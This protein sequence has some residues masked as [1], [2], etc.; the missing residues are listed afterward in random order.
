MDP[1]AP[2]GPNNGHALTKGKALSNAMRTG[3]RWLAGVAAGALGA[4]L[5]VGLTAAPAQANTYGVSLAFPSLTLV[6]TN[7]TAP[8]IP[9]TFTVNGNKS[10]LTGFNLVGQIV[11]KDD[12]SV[13]GTSTSTFFNDV[14]RLNSQ[15]STGVSSWTLTNGT[16]NSAA[17]Y[18]SI[19]TG[20]YTLKV[21]ATDATTG[22]AVATTSMPFAVVSAAS[23]S[24][25]AGTAAF[26]SAQDWATQKAA[27]PLTVSTS[28]SVSAAGTLNVAFLNS[29]GGPIV[30]PVGMFTA[31]ASPTSVSGGSSYA[32]VAASGT[33]PGIYAFSG[34]S[35]TWSST[36]TTSGTVKAYF[37][38]PI[39]QITGTLGVTVSSAATMG[40]FNITSAIIGSAGTMTTAADDSA[41]VPTTSGVKFTVSAVTNTT[42]VSTSVPT[43]GVPVTFSVAGYQG[44]NTTAATAYSA[45][46]PALPVAT[47]SGGGGV[48]SQEFTVSNPVASN[49][50][51]V[52]ATVPGATYTWFIQFSTPTV[53]SVSVATRNVTA[54]N[55]GTVTIAGTVLDNFDEPVANWPVQAA[56]TGVAATSTPA[57]LTS[58][59]D[60]NV[61][62][63]ITV[64]AS[65]PS[66]AISN[67][68][69]T[70]WNSSA[71]SFTGT[72]STVVVTYTSGSA[73]VAT[74]TTQGSFSPL[75]SAA[76]ANLGT[77][78]K[79]NTA[80]N[81]MYVN[82]AANLTLA[83][84]PSA[85]DGFGWQI[86]TTATNAAGTAIAGAAIEVAAGDGGYVVS[87]ITGKWVKEATF[88]TSST[89]VNQIVFGSTKTGEITYTLK[90]GSVTQTVA[91]VYANRPT[92]ART[93]A[94]ASSSEKVPAG[95]GATITATV[96]DRFGN[97]V[98]GVPVTFTETGPGYI[99]G[100]GGGTSGANGRLEATY[101]TVG[102]QSGTATVGAVVG[103]TA[104]VSLPSALPSAAD[105][106]PAAA[107]TYTLQVGNAADTVTSYA[108]PAAS[109]T[110]VSSTVRGVTAGVASA[111]LVIEVTDVASKSITIVGE[112]TTVS[113][114]SG[115]KVDGIV[116]GIE[117]GK[118]V[119]PFIRFP[120]E[121]TFTEG[122]ARPAIS[123][124]EFTW[125]RKTGKR[126]TVYVTSDD[127]LVTSNRVTIQA[128]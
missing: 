79:L 113:G 96:T 14:T 112:R 26:V 86:K 22:V 110:A 77:G 21:T 43:A 51:R 57:S 24:G 55:T 15:A 66:G 118:T 23:A 52:T 99:A 40:S 84:A 11:D 120:G 54:A 19:A 80:K 63:T 119:K 76:F 27:T 90:S 56:V 98:P 36:P 2:G 70:P 109:T 12:S 59:K 58:D 81:P 92:D 103:S 121:T 13:I 53:S 9:V 33:A 74:L 45:I 97:P 68:T 28:S 34:A 122:T 39:N 5:L 78:N 44:N 128:S 10:A 4:G 73:A 32:T 16:S 71:G 25:V 69:F 29:A 116:E 62:Y 67:L 87:P 17:V 126:V 65:T 75:N 38:N 89:G 31:V 94:V 8:T 115:I 50:V 18:T 127:G 30:A 102:G 111:N 100:S 117:D 72:P 1:S 46:S 42:P 83:Y 123:G 20:A 85:A 41:A 114:K 125:Q 104:S 49:G 35:G 6:Q 106:V 48:V 88:Y 7:V 105:Q 107:G 82:T 61:S 47:V 95:S 37:A 64:P 108:I 93:V 101:V 3:K 91:A 60:G 124:G